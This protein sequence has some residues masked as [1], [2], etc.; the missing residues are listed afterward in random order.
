MD[1]GVLSILEKRD[2]Q[3]YKKFFDQNKNFVDNYKQF[4][5]HVISSLETITSEIEE[6]PISSEKVKEL[7]S[8]MKNYAKTFCNDNGIPLSRPVST[9]K[10][11]ICE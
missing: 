9:G 10:D 6:E 1:N 2:I 7:V 4:A 3:K 5:L 11:C 8:I